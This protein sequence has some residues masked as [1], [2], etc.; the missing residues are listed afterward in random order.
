MMRLLSS[1]TAG[2][3]TLL[4][5]TAPAAAQSSYPSQSVKILVPFGA[6]S[7]TDSLA[8]IIA[9]VA[10]RDRLLPLHRDA[11]ARMI[12]QGAPRDDL[13]KVISGHVEAL[14]TRIGRHPDRI[15]GQRLFD[16]LNAAISVLE[17]LTDR[18]GIF[19]VPGSFREPELFH[20]AHAE[21][22]H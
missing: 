19:F 4:A 9:D 2:I 22:R 10:R 12:E 16:V 14:R 8:R 15:G 7:V 1:L 20:D 6:G 21:V 11:V 3:A 5:A 13:A 18:I 17:K